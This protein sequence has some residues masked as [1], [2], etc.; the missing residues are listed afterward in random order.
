MS[1]NMIEEGSMEK[2]HDFD[3]LDDRELLNLLISRIHRLESD[4]K[5]LEAKYNDIPIY[6]NQANFIGSLILLFV[7]F[8]L[9]IAPYLG[10][11]R[12]E[13]PQVI[14]YIAAFANIFV[15]YLVYK[16]HKDLA[17][18]KSFKRNTKYALMD[19]KIALENANK[20][21]AAREVEVSQ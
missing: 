19:A 1:S 5:R 9:T 13:I 14:S 20:Q 4:V 18:N 15:A 11:M 8:G 3:H 12:F 17:V 21:Y 10:L 7:V 6:S 16:T 2:K